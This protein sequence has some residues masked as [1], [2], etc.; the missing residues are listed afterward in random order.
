M[1]LRI[2]ICKKHNQAEENKGGRVKNNK[3]DTK[4]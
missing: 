2:H 3:Q 1:K 4:K